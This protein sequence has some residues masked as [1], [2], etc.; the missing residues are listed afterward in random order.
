MDKVEE[1]ARI[2]RERI[3]ARLSHVKLAERAGVD[4]ATW[5]RVRKNPESLTLDTLDKLEKAI[6]SKRTEMADA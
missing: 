6:K 1:V 4:A 3:E 5:W 2:D